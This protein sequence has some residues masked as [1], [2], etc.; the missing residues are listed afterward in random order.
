MALLQAG[1]RAFSNPVF[2]SLSL[3][4]VAVK[5]AILSPAPC[6]P[7]AANLIMLDSHLSG[8]IS[9]KKLSFLVCLWPWWVLFFF[10]KITIAE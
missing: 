8:T 9:Q 10:F 6:L 4:C 7:L 5:D 3:L 2:S 1:F